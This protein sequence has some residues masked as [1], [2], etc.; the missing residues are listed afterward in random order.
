[1]SF[2]T[3]QFCLDNKVVSFS[4]GITW[5]GKKK[6]DTGSWG[7]L[8]AET[9]AKH[10]NNKKNGFA[11]IMGLNNL[12][13]IDCDIAKAAGTFP[14][15]LLE[16]MDSCCKAVVKTPNGIH[17][18]FRG[19]GEGISSWW[20]G[21]RVPCLDILS[22]KKIALAPPS[23]YTK[24]DDVVQYKWQK[25]DL[26]VVGEMPSELQLLFSSPAEASANTKERERATIPLETMRRVL[27]GISPQRWKQYKDWLDIG[28]ILYN[29]GF[30]LA[31]WDEYSKSI[32]GYGNTGCADKWRSFRPSSKPLRIGTLYKM[33]KEDD[34]E[35]FNE[36]CADRVKLYERLIMGHTNARIAE[37][38]YLLN[39]N[40]YIYSPELGWYDLRINNTYYNTEKEPLI[41]KRTVLDSLTPLI[42]ESLDHYRQK[43]QEETDEKQKDVLAEM[44]KDLYKAMSVIESSA[45]MVGVLAWLK[46]Y[47]CDVTVVN[48]MDK[49]KNLLAFND[50]VWDFMESKY[51][52]IQPADYISITTGYDAPDI[53]TPVH[54]VLQKFLS[55]L[56]EDQSKLDYVLKVMAYSL[57]GENKFQEFYIFQGDNGGNGKS[58]LMLL[59]MI[60]SGGYYASIPSAYIT[61]NE[62]KKSAPKPELAM[63]ANARIVCMAE[64]DPTKSIQ[65]KFL[66]DITGGDQQIVRKLHLNPFSF[67]PQF[68]PFIL[69][70][71]VKFAKPGG[72]VSRRLRY[73]K[74]PFDFR[75]S[76]KHNPENESSRLADPDLE[77]QLKTNVEIRN[78]FM[79]LLLR[80]FRDKVKDST[81]ILMP[82]IVK[83]ET[84]EFFNSQVPI[85]GWLLK[86][87][88]R[89]GNITTDKFS[90][91]EMAS[92][93]QQDT[94]DS[95]NAKM[96]GIYLS[97]LGVPKKQYLGKDYYRGL[98]RIEEGE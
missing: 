10:H 78:S 40:K 33:L 82:P 70:N 24:G 44:I 52:P 38:F 25:G 66:K 91:T 5:D 67:I 11:I 47:Y 32:G 83:Q 95:I 39:P 29:E 85:G 56:F 98:V 88:S 65:E 28:I 71:P 7:E 93:Y 18:Y 16:A 41:W 50:M 4:L 27:E 96:M 79:A 69:C 34:K 54:P 8:T 45:F 31:L 17:Y 20:K 37:T 23:L 22:D 87:Y 13:V 36:I 1:M 84:E 2:N 51:R 59:L 48:K 19:G 64:P 80:T 81:E 86:H 53:D 77:K 97:T 58:L 55:S 35:L 62:D 68:T 14:S 63:A 92:A 6:L 94:G 49:H 9:F 60:V 3:R 42:N 21:E 89:N 43:C 57:W 46:E 75:S 76:Q 61:D 74:F 90:A 15:S 12:F 72:A 26:S 73:I 30:E